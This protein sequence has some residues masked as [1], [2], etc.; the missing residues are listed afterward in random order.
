MRVRDIVLLASAL[1]F[2]SPA[3]AAQVTFSVT[4]P[5]TSSGL[6]WNIGDPLTFS[7]SIPDSSAPTGSVPDGQYTFGDA[8]MSLAFGANVFI[9]PGATI[10]LA[11]LPPGECCDVIF[12]DSLGPVT[13]P[14]ALSDIALVDFSFSHELLDGF[15]GHSLAFTNA[16]WGWDNAG[17][18]WRFI[19]PVS[20]DV[21]Q[22]VANIEDLHEGTLVVSTPE[23][24]SLLLLGL[25]LG[26][27]ALHR[28]RR[29][30]QRPAASSARAADSMPRRL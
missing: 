4:T 25:S 1:S 14:P 21:I 10:R 17:I 29:R 24:S 28:H 19:D 23:P 7:F 18:P 5:Q 9:S 20:H 26:G 11:D 2:A 12:V 6:F 30:N 15:S 13:S 22:A 8:T 16:V 27:A 3:A